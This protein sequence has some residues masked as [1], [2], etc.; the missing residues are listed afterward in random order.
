MAVYKKKTMR[1]NEMLDEKIV[2]EGEMLRYKARGLLAF[3]DI[4]YDANASE[5]DFIEVNL[6]EAIDDLL[7]MP[8]TVVKE[9]LCTQLLAGQRFICFIYIKFTF[10]HCRS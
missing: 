8:R 10:L 4:P 7:S 2:Q 3:G 1:L 5:Q 6:R 9:I